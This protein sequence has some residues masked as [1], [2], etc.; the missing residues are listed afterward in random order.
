M[1][2]R[3]RIPFWILGVAV[4]L[5]LILIGSRVGSGP[6]NPALQQRFTPQTPG[7]G[8]PTAAPLALP[9]IELPSLP[10]ELQRQVAELRRRL[11]GGEAVPAL[12]P[13][14]EGSQLRVEVRDLRREGEQLKV[15]GTVTNLG[16]EPLSV[17]PEAFSFRDSA[18]VTYNV[19]GS[20]GVELRPGQSTALDLTLPV[21]AG[22]GV[23][24]ILS[25]PP[26]PPQEQILAVETAS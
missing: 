18:G 17:P 9:R 22:R 15:S 10:P 23:V 21:P 16:P 4:A 7:P 1:D 11:D 13:V 2:D 24:L 5:V 6:I 19:A 26:D 14:A 12:T 3:H 25:L 20:E 8:T